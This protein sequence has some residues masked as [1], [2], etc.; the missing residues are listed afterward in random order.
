MRERLSMYQEANVATNC[1]HLS[2][3]QRAGRA[4]MDFCQSCGAKGVQKV[5]EAPRGLQQTGGY[6]TRPTKSLP[7]G[8]GLRCAK[9][10]GQ[11]LDW[12]TSNGCFQL[13]T[14]KRC[15]PFHTMQGQDAHPSGTGLC[16][17]LAQLAV[18]VCFSGIGRN[19]HAE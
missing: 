19:G 13:Q 6:G 5:F 7:R 11:G 2:E 18:K 16:F 14:R 17:K 3:K 10:A 8:S 9:I 15:V 12:E 1:G 4:E